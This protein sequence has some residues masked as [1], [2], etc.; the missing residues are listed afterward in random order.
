MRRFTTI[1]LAAT[2]AA[3]LAFAQGP[4]PMGGQDMSK[5]R[6]RFLTRQLNLSD[7]QAAKATKIFDQS[8]TDSQTLRSSLQSNRTELQAAVKKGDAEAID[9]LAAAN[10][11]ITG[12]ILAIESKAD[13]AFYA[14]LTAEQQSAYD[15]ISQRGPGMM[16]G[17]GRMGGPGG[18]PGG[19]GPNQ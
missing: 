14:I 8:S 17:P 15:E 6:I 7:E 10:G 12:Q 19:E 11:K 5:M 4:P 2:M 3:A 9:Q 18:G 16:G 1:C 13:A